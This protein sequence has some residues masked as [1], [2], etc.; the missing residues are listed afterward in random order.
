MRNFD[1]YEFTGIVAPGVILI[2]SSLLAIMDPVDLL[3]IKLGASFIFIVVAYVSGH[4]LQ[5]L[6]NWFEFVWWKVFGGMPTDWVQKKAE[7]I[8]SNDQR[9]KLFS[10]IERNE[11]IEN[12]RLSQMGHRDWFLLVRSLYVVIQACGQVERIERFNGN[13]GML[14][15][16]SV[17]CFI[18]GLIIF[19]APDGKEIYGAALIIA[20]ILSSIRMHRFAKYY[21]RELFL[22]YIK[23]A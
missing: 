9:Q 11:G 19:M 6:G 12:S 21:A 14:R 20:G 13:Y 1:F 5:S 15:G 2:A 16:V 17:S 23:C 22:Q 4:I 18:S 3:E 7:P 8:L 10:A